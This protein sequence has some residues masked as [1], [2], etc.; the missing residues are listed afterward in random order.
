MHLQYVMSLFVNL[1][2]VPPYRQSTETTVLSRKPPP[3]LKNIN[4]EALIPGMPSRDF[5]AR[6][7]SPQAGHTCCLLTAGGCLAF[8]GWDP[9]KY[10]D[11]YGLAGPHG[12]LEYPT[13][14]RQPSGSIHLRG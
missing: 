12:G 2:S 11:T 4:A 8:V 6:G 1:V 9:Q 3:P 13:A 5:Q 7:I 10:L 14:K